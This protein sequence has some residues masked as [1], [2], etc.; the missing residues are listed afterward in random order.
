[1]IKRFF[2]WLDKITTPPDS[3]LINQE[4]NWQEAVQHRS[5]FYAPTYAVFYRTRES[6][7]LRMK[8][9]T[10]DVNGGVV[11]KCS[12]GGLVRHGLYLH[13]DDL[14][15]CANVCDSCGMGGRFIKCPKC[16]SGLAYIKCCLNKKV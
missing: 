8:L 3:W 7:A 14:R 15:I 11:T 6:D 12:C 16:D 9:G 4:N 10:K 2:N 5:S 13:E 1:M